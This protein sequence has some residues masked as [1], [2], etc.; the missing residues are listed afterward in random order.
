MQF[1]IKSNLFNNIKQTLYNS[2]AN[3]NKIFK[4]KYSQLNENF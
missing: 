2:K 4:N 3:P 1:G